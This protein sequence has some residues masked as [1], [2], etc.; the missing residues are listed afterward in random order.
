M[1]IVI[2]F[3]GTCVT[4]AYPAIGEDIG[5]VPVLKKITDAGHRLILFTMR[6]DAD[7]GEY[8]TAAIDWFIDN[9]ISLYGVQENPDQHKWTTSPKAYGQ[10]IIDDAALGCPLIFDKQM[11]DRPYV[12]WAE[13][14]Y[15]LK[16][17]GLYE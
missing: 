6:C 17:K 7:A 2:D 14:D 16:C 12:D 8:L 13:V 3:D 5:A 10:L 1:D 15:L 11:S 9:G 4:H